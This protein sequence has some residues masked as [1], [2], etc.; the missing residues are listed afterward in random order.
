MI[1]II[2]PV[3]KAE[4]YLH[5]CVD[6][7]LAQTFTDFELLLVDD[8]SPDHSSAICDQY[9]AA[10]PRVC[11][12]HKPNGGVSSARNLGIDN[13]RGEWITFVDA[14][15]WIDEGLINDMVKS[16]FNTDCVVS[17]SLSYEWPDK[18]IIKSVDYSKRVFENVSDFF[19]ENKFCTRG[20]GGACS[21]LFKKTIVE[22]NKICFLVGTCLYEDT[23]FTL[24]YLSKCNRVSI[25]SKSKYHYRHTD[26]E[27]L[28]K[29]KHPFE[30]YIQ[31]ANIGLNILENFEYSKKLSFGYSKYVSLYIGSLI[32][33][34][35]DSKKPKHIRIDVINMLKVIYKKNAGKYSY[36]DFAR[37]IKVLYLIT[38]FLINHIS[39]SLLILIFKFS[40]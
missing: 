33:L 15:D 35:R 3:Y 30:A 20:D 26:Q 21:K 1:S 5:R 8:G 4:K 40:K 11:V 23:N 37:N 10:D 29:T 17:T 24:Q 9:A 39:D 18:T 25:V 16:A 36:T 38:K 32:P 19:F 6:S 14:D 31:C 2:I 12:F 13:A 27:S 34:Y 7:I 22:S 28:S